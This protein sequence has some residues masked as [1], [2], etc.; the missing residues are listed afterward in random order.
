MLCQL[1][2]SHH[3]GSI[4]ATAFRGVPFRG[5]GR[6]LRMVQCVPGLRGTLQLLVLI[7]DSQ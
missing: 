2:Y 6:F 4:I 7:A 3:N 1:S 5:A